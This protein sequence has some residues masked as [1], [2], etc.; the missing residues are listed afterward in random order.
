[1]R[2]VST[3][4]RSQPP[5][6]RLRSH[7]P[8]RPREQSPAVIR[9]LDVDE[10]GRVRLATGIDLVRPPPEGTIR[11]VD[12]QDQDAPSLELLRERFDFHPLAIEDC[13]HFDQRSKVEEYTDTLFVVTHGVRMPE[14]GQLELLELHA[15]LGKSFLV[16]V[17]A[18]PM[19][20]VDVVWDRVAGDPGLARRGTDY[21]Y[22]LV[23]DNTVDAL[24]PVLDR[25]G[26]RIEAIELSV[27]EDPTPDDLSEMFVLRRLLSSLRRVLSPQRDAFALMAKRGAQGGD[28]TAP[29]FRDVFDHVARLAESIDMHRDM[30]GNCF[31]A[32]LSGVSNKTNGVMKSL[33]VMSAI[34][35]PLS[36]IVGFFGQNFDDFPLFPNWIHSDQLMWIMFTSCVAVPGLLLVTFRRSGWW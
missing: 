30:L 1:M 21:L 33:T 25:I 36:F 32:Y 29:Y 15:F 2:S 13:M 28:R 12:L 31:D 5:T 16:T 7:P 9:V 26:D 34:F 6:R 14:D 20:T 3:S 8:A 19:P 24:F 18:L 10:K 11:W 23:V 35:L 4:S 22:Y 17:H 27:L